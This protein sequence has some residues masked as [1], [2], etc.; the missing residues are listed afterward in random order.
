[1]HTKF[2]NFRIAHHLANKRVEPL[3]NDP[4]PPEIL[5]HALAGPSKIHDLR[6][7]SVNWA[8]QLSKFWRNAACSDPG[9]YTA[10]VTQA[11]IYPHPV[12]SVQ[13]SETCPFSLPVLLTPLILL[14]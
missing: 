3:S 11:A 9:L 1:M 7:F 12:A 4:R 8:I 10:G 14:C 6:F 2:P 5:G 13:L